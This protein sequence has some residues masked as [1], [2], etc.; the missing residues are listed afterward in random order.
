[1]P[2]MTVDRIN[3][4]GLPRP[5]GFTH[6][7][8]VPAGSRIVFLAGQTGTGAGVAEQFE[9]ALRNVLT[10][11]TAVG[12]QASDLVGLTIYSTDLADY[13]AHAGEIGAIW[14]HLIGRE[15]PA[16]AAIGVARLWEPD[17][18]VE[19]QATAAI[20]SLSAAAR[21]AWPARRAARGSRRTAPRLRFPPRDRAAA[22]RAARD[23]GTAGGAS[24]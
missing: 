24:R 18:L 14:R 22:R 6:V 21:S 20:G 11:L 7:V 15:Y 13:R 5:S 8:S 4:P 10:A 12:G 23:R 2:F 9:S 17:A 19:L 1:M 16:T 3:P